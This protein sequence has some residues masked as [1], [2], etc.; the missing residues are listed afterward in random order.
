[1]PL[2]APFQESP[3]GVAGH[4]EMLGCLAL[5]M[6]PDAGAHVAPDRSLKTRSGLRRAVQRS[7][8]WLRDDQ[9]PGSAPQ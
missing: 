3:Q 6:Q 8:S 5:S 1:M 4:A 2:V 9:S 7:C